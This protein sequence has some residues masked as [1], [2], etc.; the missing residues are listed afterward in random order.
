LYR[1]Q[2]V[3]GTA[4]MVQFTN[5]GRMLYQLIVFLRVTSVFG[6]LLAHRVSAVD[7]RQTVLAQGKSPP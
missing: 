3:N 1:R 7:D 2:D 6:Y 4:I 5:G